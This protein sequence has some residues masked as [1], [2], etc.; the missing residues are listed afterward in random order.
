MVA[1]MPCATAAAER[2]K[3]YVLRFPASVLRPAESLAID[4]L[5]IVVSCAEFVAI[6][7]IPS[8]WNVGISRPISAQSGFHASAGHGASALFDLSAFDGVIAVSS[9]DEGCLQAKATAWSTSGEWTR[10]I[11]GIRFFE[12]RRSR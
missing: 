2:S 5:R 10:E 11:T 12:R 8:D 3:T 1:L 6:E 7:R 4:R 9:D